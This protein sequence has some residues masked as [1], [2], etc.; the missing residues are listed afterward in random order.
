LNQPLR[1]AARISLPIGFRF[2][3]V[4]SS[5]FPK[6]VATPAPPL[7]PLSAF[8]GTFN[9]AGFNIIFRPNNAFTPT[10]LPT[11]VV[12]VSDNILELNL[13]AETL[14]FSS[15][16]GAVPN[17]GSNP[18]GNVFLNGVPYLQ[19]INDVTIPHQA[20]GIHLEPGLWVIVPQTNAPLEETTVARMASIPHGTTIA[21]Q[22]TSTDIAGAP[23]IPPV[24]ITPFRTGNPAAKIPF[25]SQ[26]A[27]NAA[28]ARIPQDLTAFIDAG[29]ITQAILTDP[30]TVLRHH[31]SG[32]KIAA[33]T[34]ISIS[35]RPP[36]PLFGG[37]LDNIAFL[38]GDETTPLPNRPNAQTLQMT[39]TFW[40]ETVELTLRVPIYRRG[41][42]PLSIKPVPT[43]PGQHVPTFLVA[44]PIDIMEPR[45]IRVS[46]TQIQYSQTVLLNFSSITWPH[47][48]V[49]T[50]IPSDPIPVPPSAWD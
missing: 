38:L 35:T 17:R 24:D 27:A 42:P 49:A 34:V 40:V 6:P 45:E 13:T 44:P 39:A 7:G 47:V 3:E 5:R 50:L 32:Q 1:F 2:D 19:V 31:L 28:T 48:S 10:H 8:T 9:G 11:P 16:L 41:H 20:T 25:P 22:G 43:V 33:T 37:G 18:Q 12:P 14:T 26:T 4:T 23:T 30:N 15:S 29:T 21:A 36:E 46:F